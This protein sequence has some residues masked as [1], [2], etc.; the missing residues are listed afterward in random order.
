M[1]LRALFGQESGA[2]ALI[3]SRL[4]IEP[5]RSPFVSMRVDV[6]LAAGT[7]EEIITRVA[8]LELDGRTFKVLYL[9]NGLK[10]TYEQ[11]RELE[12]QIGGRIRGKADMRRP[13]VTFGLLS[14]DDGWMFGI[15]RPADPVWQNHK[16]KPQNYSTG[17]TTVVARALVNIAV[18]DPQDM[19]AIDPCCGMGNVL[20]EA[21]SMGIDIVGR[22][23]N[24]LAVRGAR[25]NLRHFGYEDADLV[26]IGDLND[27][28]EAFDAA[29]VDMPYNL[30]SI[31]SASERSLMLASVRRIS[32]RAVIVSSESLES[33]IEA[34]G[35]KIMDSCSVSKGTFVRHVWLTT[36][37]P[38]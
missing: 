38:V 5:N 17:L 25:V 6:L 33:E 24:P 28:N 36:Q 16:D 20:I 35:L 15:C 21:L 14:L 7:L 34:A 9:K 29:I 32:K 13:D 3:D 11:R 2:F 31:L 1:E 37:Q 30:C 12:R 22:D 4:R 19:R 26:A 18:P 10:R 23:I 27:I 8:E